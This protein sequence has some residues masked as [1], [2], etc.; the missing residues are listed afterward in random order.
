ME[1]F[2]DIKGDAQKH[3]IEQKICY[4]QI[5]IWDLDL[6]DLESIKA[7]IPTYKELYDKLSYTKDT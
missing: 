4:L 2:D 6:N 1:L 5:K 3:K 7:L